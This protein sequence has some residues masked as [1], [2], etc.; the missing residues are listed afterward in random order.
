[1]QPTLVPT[2]ATSQL[3]FPVIRRF[4]NGLTVI[5][6]QMPIDAVNLSLWLKVGSALESDAI[7]GTAHFLEHMIFKG[8]PRIRCGEFEKLVEERGAVTN[9]VTS[10][11]YTHFYITSA[12]QDFATLTPLHVDLV[13]NPSINDQDFERERPVILEE[14]RRSQSNPR[15]RTFYRSMELAFERLPYRRQ[16]LGPATVIEQ[17]SP[18][19]M[20]EFHQRWYQPHNVT[21]VAVGNLPVDELVATVADSFEQAIAHRQQHHPGRSEATIPQPVARPEQPFHTIHR[22]DHQDRS[23]QQARLLLSWRVPGISALAQ[24][25]ALDV[26]ASILGRG[27]T[28]RLIREL[29]EER[30]LVTGIS[31]SNM[32]YDHQGV[33]SISAQLE[34]EHLTAVETAIAQQVQSLAEHGVTD[35]E[36]RRVQTQVANRYV[37]GSE[38]PSDRAGLY[39]YYQTMTGDI[40]HA[41][42]Y[43]AEIQALTVEDLQQAVQEFLPS[44]AYGVMTVIPGNQTE[45]N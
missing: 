37:F 20:R 34:V 27:R 39:G 24:T 5:A 3:H 45:Q 10:Q 21:A 1:M 11:D 30:Q 2:A 23:L 6:E 14:I 25:Y 7:N 4:P 41:L 15:R 19:T 40:S 26:V 44:H 32:T 38:T 36:L 9:A 35:D 13:M 33:F 18:Q 22:I 17:L 28:A 42:N 16:V 8:T 12:P 31:A 43:P 29:R